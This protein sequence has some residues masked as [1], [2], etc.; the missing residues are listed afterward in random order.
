[1]AQKKINADFGKNYAKTD[2][3]LIIMLLALYKKNSKLRSADNLYLAVDCPDQLAPSAYKDMTITVYDGLLYMLQEQH[4]EFTYSQL[5]ESAITDYLVLPLTFYTNCFSPLYTIVGSK[6][7]TMQKATAA[8][9]DT[10]TI[11]HETFTLVDGCCATGS[12]FFGL[13]NYNWKS[14]ILNDL[15]PLRTNF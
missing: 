2:C 1:M 3:L 4:P 10:M 15:N 7:H 11:P 8:T 6:N 12:L 14:V 13:K 9:V 5:I